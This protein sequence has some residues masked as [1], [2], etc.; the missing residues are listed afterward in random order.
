MSLQFEERD[1]QS[2]DG[3]SVGFVMFGSGP[4]LV[5]VHGSAGK[6]DAWL[7]VAEAIA[8]QFTC[9]LVDRRG[10]GRSGDARQHSLD[11]E[12]E[13]IEAVLRV[14]GAGAHLLGHSYGA[15]CALEAARRFPVGRLVLYEPPL[16]HS[17]SRSEELSKQIHSAMANDQPDEALACF[18][19]GGPELSADE[20]S[21]FQATPLWKE[22]VE[23]APTFA[24]E[25]EAINR[26]ESN[27]EPYRKVSMPTLL[28]VG[29]ASAAHLR[30]ASRGLQDTLPNVRTVL[31][32]GQ[33]HIAN[34]L[35]PD[36]VAREVSNFLLASL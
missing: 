32:D 12:C 30:D 26:L 18:L 25:V 5:L 33:A 8:G 21:A 16:F 7:P 13:D 14:A 2:A 34:L 1:V 36:L 15:I 19:R 23:L 24:R 10:R 9:H 35:A 27:L 29:T 6:G 4:P 28:L 20:L 31:L 17:G 22:A 3:T 11:R